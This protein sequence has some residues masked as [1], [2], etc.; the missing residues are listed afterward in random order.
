MAETL[1]AD[2]ASGWQISFKPHRTLLQAGHDPVSLI[3][4]L[5]ALGA[6]TVELDS[7]DL[8]PFTELAPQDCFLSWQLRLESEVSLE[9]VNNIFDGLQ[10]DCELSILPLHNKRP[11]AEKS[12]TSLP[13][14]RSESGS[15]KEAQAHTEATTLS[16]EQAISVEGQIIQLADQRYILP[17]VSIIES[18]DIEPGSIKKLAAK[19]EV[20]RL[21]DEY[22]PLIRLHEIF[23]QTG[24]RDHQDFGQLLIV[25]S[26]GQ[27]FGLLVDELLSQQSVQCKP[28]ETNYRKV[29]GMSGATVLDD[30]KVTLILDIAGLVDLYR[31]PDLS[32]DNPGSQV[33]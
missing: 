9:A 3:R 14:A 16:P 29:R 1:A 12:A 31:K 23:N 17:A 13:T 25:T 21:R 22:V 18:F 2:T 19:A 8:P 33:A 32:A 6:L 24:Q 28:L 7:S 5:G 10:D 4:E 11:D 30:G 27:K 26:E 15:E 20:Y